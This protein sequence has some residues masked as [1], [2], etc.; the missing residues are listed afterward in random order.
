MMILINNSQHKEW[1]LG[2]KYRF[3]CR[4]SQLNCTRLRFIVDFR[5]AVSQLRVVPERVQK[6]EGTMWGWGT[7]TYN[8]NI[9]SPGAVVINFN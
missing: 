1:E 2:L 9:N 8:N 6:G 7:S 3:V 4:N 5:K